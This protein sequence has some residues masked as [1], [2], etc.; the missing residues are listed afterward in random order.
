MIIPAILTDNPRIAQERATL[1][2][3]MTNRLHIDLVDETL[4]PGRSLPAVELARLVIPQTDIE[5]HLMVRDPLKY[6]VDDFPIDRAIIHVELPNWRSIYGEIQNRGIDPW[7]AVSPETTIRDL[8][9]PTD[10]VGLLLMGVEPGR[11]G[12]D[13]LPD[14]GD[15]IR[16]IKGY[17]PDLA[18]T[19]DGGVQEA[20]IHSLAID[21]A[22]N[23]V[24]TSALFST[25]DPIASYQRLTEVGEIITGGTRDNQTASD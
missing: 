18:V 19:V 4:Y 23:F 7:L 6:L 3:Q 22:D 25:R 16:E 5:V 8:D 21:G 13:L 10:L 1:A 11:S 24:S 9:L 12:Q 15:R 2:S 20:N 17:W 14:T